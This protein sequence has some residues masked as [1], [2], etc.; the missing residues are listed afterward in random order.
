MKKIFISA[1]AMFAI[2]SCGLNKLAKGNEAYDN[3]A[4]FQAARNYEEIAN[5]KQATNLFGKIGYCYLKMNQVSTALTWYKK[6]VDSNQYQDEDLLNYAICLQQ[7]GELQSAELVIDKYLLKYPGSAR[8]DLLKKS[9]VV[10]MSYKT[11]PENWNLNQI[12][13]AKTGS[14]FSPAYYDHGIVFCSASEDGISTGWDGKRYLDL[15]HAKFNSTGGFDSL[16]SLG[17][18]INSPFHEGPAVFTSKSDHVFF[19]RNYTVDGKIKK[20]DKD[21]NN[22]KIY[23]AEFSGDNWA[24]IHPLSFCSDQFNCAHPALSKDEKWLYFSS[25]MPGGYGGFD[26]YRIQL[27]GNEQAVPE[28]LGSDINGIG[29]ELFP[30]INYDPVTQTE[31]L[32]FSSDLKPGL[33]GLDIYRTVTNDQTQVDLVGY[34][35]N[36][37]SDDFGLIFIE[38]A[39]SGYF[40]SSRNNTE[41]LDH[42]YKYSRINQVFYLKGI[43]KNKKDQTP[44]GGAD[45][46][47]VQTNGN[48]QH[49]MVTDEN[50]NFILKIDT[51][52]SFELQ[53]KKIAFYKGYTHTHS[54]GM[55][56]SDT[57]E[58]ELL[59]DPV[60]LNLAIRLDNIYY[61]YNKWDI[62]SDAT[63]ELDKMVKILQ[64]NP[65]INIELSSHTDVRGNDKFNM[66]LSQK[67]AQSAVDYIISKGIDASRIYAKGYGESVVLNRCKNKVKC[68]EEEHQL[69][70]RTEFKVVNISR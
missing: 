52:E 47:I 34:P 1:I 18:N 15:Y 29:N 11:D 68:T 69:N 32:Y 48:D 28:N 49:N 31:Y 3:M 24:N 22:L 58:V 5:T 40:S 20:N 9:L 33:G 17:T 23:S 10:Q 61:D 30:T 27:N 4:Y 57:L 59:L 8:A 16:H 25:D 43:V 42:I 21:E 50:G 70:R 7:T 56:R 53:A 60:I 39:D 55:T 14:Q 63:V 45:V 65:E 38:G 51:N 54:F 35:V 46:V 36:S 2:S 12:N 66:D 6:A 41:G 26:L 62:R 44:I 37:A 67:R 64:E 19:T 13:L